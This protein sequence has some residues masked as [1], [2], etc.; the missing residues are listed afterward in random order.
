MGVARLAII[1]RMG[2]WSAAAIATVLAPAI[3]IWPIRRLSAPGDRRVL[4]LGALLAL[5]LQPLAF[6]AIPMPLHHALEAMLG[7]GPVLGT[8]SLFYAPLTEEPAKWLV[9]AFPL[10]RRAL[11][12]DNA[13]AIA[14]AVGLGFAIGEFWFIASRIAAAPGVAELPFWMFSGYLFE[15]LQVAFPHGAFILW[16]A[17]A[18]AGG[19]RCGPARWLAWRCISRSTF[20]SC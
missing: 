19:G 12:P 14:L 9:L 8:L 6:H 7:P 4:L 11:R 1:R 20:R 13:M 17:R 3:L 5:P 15:R 16:F 2:I 18:F 10:S